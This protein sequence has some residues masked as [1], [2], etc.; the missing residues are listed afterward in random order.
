MMRSLDE[1]RDVCERYHP[2]L[3]AALA[4]IPLAE[5][6]APGG[7][8]LGLFR[9]FGGPGLLVPPEYGGAGVDAL[10]AARVVRAMSSYSPSL[11][12][13]TTMHHY[14]VATLFSL[15]ETAGRLTSA[16]L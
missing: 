10:S 9:K 11:G 6:E 12:A 7:P 8:V 13:A 4:E 1:A 16:Q 3:C 2:G 15:A 5:R 14:T